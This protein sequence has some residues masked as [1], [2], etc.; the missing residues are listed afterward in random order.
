MPQ[1]FAGTSG[2]NYR[3]W[4]GTFYPETLPA[5]KYLGFYAQN[6][7]SAEVNYSFYHLPKVQTYESWY[8]TAPADFVFALKLSRFITHI[9]RLHDVRQPWT[10]FLKGARSLKEKLGPIL[11]QFPPSFQANEENLRRIGEFLGYASKDGVRL[12]MEFRH[13]SCFGAPMLS[14]LREYGA[15]LVIAHSSRFPVPEAMATAAFMYF[16]FHGPREWC[17]SAY[18]K[19]ELTNWGHAIRSFMNQGL[20]AYAYFN[21]DA[22]GDAPPNAKLLAEIVARSKS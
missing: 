18:S 8:A 13:D 9:K 15:A 1:F 11:L 3:N 19:A 12:A 22:H 10:G 21:N 16:R 14:I 6:F 5:K 7:R 4:R 20:D 2:W 17:S